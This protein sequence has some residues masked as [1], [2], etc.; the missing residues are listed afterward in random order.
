[1]KGSSQTKMRETDDV[2]KDANEERRGYVMDVV[3]T[4]GD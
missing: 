2:P 1:M 4:D 3:R